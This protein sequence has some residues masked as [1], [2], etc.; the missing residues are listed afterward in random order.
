MKF[1]LVTLL[2]LVSGSVLGEQQ[3]QESP[4]ELSPAES[5]NPLPAREDEWRFTIAFP[6]IW[7]PDINGKIRG[8]ERIDFTPACVTYSRS[9]T[10]ISTAR[11]G[12]RKY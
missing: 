7:T 3:D 8:G 6:M 12:T 11:S 9:L 1:A 2:V 4:A 10:S 5:G